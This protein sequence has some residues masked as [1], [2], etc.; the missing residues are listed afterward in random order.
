RKRSAAWSKTKYSGIY[1][2]SLVLRREQ[3]AVRE[4]DGGRGGA[5]PVLDRGASRARTDRGVPRAL[6]PQDAAARDGAATGRPIPRRPDIAA[7]ARARHCLG[8]QF[9]ASRGSNAP[10]SR[11]LR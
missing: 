3:P 9:A 7:A 10:A 6:R 5:A 1:N 11:R 4:R 8:R 2:F